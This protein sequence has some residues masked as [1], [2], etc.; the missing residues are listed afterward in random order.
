MT[1]FYS[2][3]PS[4][5]DSN[6]TNTPEDSSF[7]PTSN[8]YERVRSEIPVNA[9][10]N[11]NKITQ[12]LNNLESMI[13]KIYTSNID[14]KELRTSWNILPEFN[15]DDTDADLDN[16]TNRLLLKIKTYLFYILICLLFIAYN[17]HNN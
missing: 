6:G 16:V 2:D 1:L 9:S 3:I 15:L 8:I 13:R 12:R 7:L 4:Y 17:L 11:Y 14:N 5:S 10:Y